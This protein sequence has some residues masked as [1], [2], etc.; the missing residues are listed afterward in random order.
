MLWSIRFSVTQKPYLNVLVGVC[1]GAAVLSKW[2]PALIVFPIWLLIIMDS[3]KFQLRQVVIH[4]IILVVTCVVV[5]LP[6]QLYIFEM[7]PKEAKWEAGFNVKPFR[8]VRIDKFDDFAMN[9]PFQ[10]S[11]H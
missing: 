8:A 4:F 6:W 1:T 3:K 9:S 2:L 10:P 11:H 7:F 5:F